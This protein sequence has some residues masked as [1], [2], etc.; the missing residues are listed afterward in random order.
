MGQETMIVGEHPDIQAAYLTATTAANT[1]PEL[2][3][4]F[5]ARGLC[6]VAVEGDTAGDITEVV[7]PPV[8]L[9]GRGAGDVRACPHPDRLGYPEK[10]LATMTLDDYHIFL[11][12]YLSRAVAAGGCSCFVC[13]KPVRDDQPEAPWDGIFIDKEL[14]CWLIIHFDCKRGLAREFRGYHPFELAAL[15]PEPYDVTRD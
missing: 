12:R 2:L 1:D 14:V 7:A 15:P 13:R 6:R 10:P 11:L 5:L 8:L 3:D 4:W 9:L